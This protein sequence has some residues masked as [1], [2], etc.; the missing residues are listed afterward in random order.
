VKNH[1]VEI[2]Q[3]DIFQQEHSLIFRERTAKSALREQ[4]R[5]DEASQGL[6]P[7]HGAEP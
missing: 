3:P 1:A 4:A 7:V 5:E 2:F 6:C